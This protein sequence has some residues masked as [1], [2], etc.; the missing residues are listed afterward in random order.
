MSSTTRRR[1]GQ[2]LISGLVLLA[3]LAMVSANAWGTNPV[4]QINQP[5]V[6]A[7]TPA[8]SAASFTLTIN[9]CGFVQGSVVYWNST[10]RK[11]TLVSSTQVTATITPNLFSVSGTASVKVVN[12][13]PG[14]GTSNVA[15]F[16]VTSATTRVSLSASSATVSSNP[17]AVTTADFN[18]DRKQDLAVSNEGSNTISIL[19]G[20]GDGTFQS[21]VDY[22]TGAEPAG[23]ATGD[24]NRDGELDL[25]V[26]G[27]LSSS[28]AILLGNGDG[29][30][31]NAV[32]YMTGA[33][34]E[35]VATGDFNGDGL[36]DLALA[37]DSALGSASVLLGNGDGSFQNVVDFPAELL[38][39]SLSTG[40]FNGDGKL[41]L[42]AA[43]FNGGSVSVMLETTILW[44]PTGLTFASQNLGTTSAPQTVTLTNIGSQSVTVTSI[45]TARRRMRSPTPATVRSAPA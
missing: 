12:P 19:L 1:N 2:G 13:A 35:S 14:G 3:E 10:L 30:F 8:G 34:P 11:T 43:D 25:A 42:A 29:S 6:P 36:L 40:D 17:L 5:L 4:P 39:T 45:A 31:Q 20:N 41:D 32:D 37:T 7:S 26:A 27:L 33:Y 24:F 21:H 44:A 16:Q 28:V 18:G 23:L 38:P 15:F 22:A 9:G